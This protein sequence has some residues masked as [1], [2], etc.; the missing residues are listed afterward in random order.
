MGLRT[1]GEAMQTP[2][3][4]LNQEK[5]PSPSARALCITVMNT[6]PF[7]LLAHTRIRNHC[8]TSGCVRVQRPE[9]LL[10]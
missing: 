5:S 9:H 4:L 2:C 7:R 6:V 10:P 8:T 1:A 3:A